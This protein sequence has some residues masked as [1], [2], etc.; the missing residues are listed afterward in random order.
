MDK[1]KVLLLILLIIAVAAAAGYFVWDFLKN[2]SGTCLVLPQAYCDAAKETYVSGQF[3]GITANLRPGVKVYAPFDGTL[4]YSGKTSM[5]GVETGIWT[6]ENNPS[7]SLDVQSTAAVFLANLTRKLDQGKT[8]S[9]KKGEL[10]GRSI[11][12]IAAVDSYNFLADFKRYNPMVG[13]SLTDADL[14]RQFF[15]A[16]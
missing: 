13:Y 12:S 7:G 15:P 8:V 11:G 9:V 2:K 1:R 6:I 4:K 5:N 3:I 16:K 14:L 10:L